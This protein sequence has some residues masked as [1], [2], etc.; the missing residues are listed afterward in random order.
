MIFLQQ[1]YKILMNFLQQFYNYLINLG[2]FKGHIWY[3]T[4]I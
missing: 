2:V 3:K 1:F 4:F